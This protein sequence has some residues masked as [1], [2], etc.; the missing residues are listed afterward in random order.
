[1]TALTSG[2]EASL[3]DQKLMRKRAF[4]FC[5]RGAILRFKTAYLENVCLYLSLTS[6]KRLIS[7]LPR[8]LPSSQKTGSHT[9]VKRGSGHSSWPGA[10][11]RRR[12]L[13]STSFV[14]V[15]GQSKEGDG[16]HHCYHETYQVA[17]WSIQVGVLLLGHMPSIFF[18]FSFTSIY[19]CT[20]T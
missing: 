15:G 3:D 1:M 7:N 17:R 14:F 4:D 16:R 6:R 12:L 11:S 19:L 20:H 18:Y 5:R 9:E 2:I 13:A 8:K 10:E